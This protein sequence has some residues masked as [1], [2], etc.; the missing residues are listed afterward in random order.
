MILKLIGYKEK[1]MKLSLK[2][3]QMSTSEKSI[4]VLVARVARISVDFSEFFASSRHPFLRGK[5]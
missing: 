5:A 4:M 3:M 2:C 1:F